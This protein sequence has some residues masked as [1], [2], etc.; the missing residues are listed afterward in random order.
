MIKKIMLAAENKTR[1][2]V[3][4]M[5]LID[6]ILVEHKGINVP[7][8]PYLRFETEEDAMVFAMRYLL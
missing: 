7:V 5:P 6:E 4:I 3:D 2:I 1:N 8:S